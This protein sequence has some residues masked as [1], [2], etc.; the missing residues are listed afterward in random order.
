ME[1]ETK[2]SIDK[3][4]SDITFKVGH[5]VITTLKGVFKNFDASIYTKSK[6]FQ[7][8]EIDFWIEAASVTTG[9]LNRDV[10]LRSVDFFD[11]Q[12][13]MQ[14]K[15]KSTTMGPPDKE[16]NHELWGELIIKGNTKLIKLNVKF[17]G[18][19]NDLNGNENVSC[20]ITGK[21]NRADWGLYGN[22]SFESGGMMVSKEVK[23]LCAL[24]LINLGSEGLHLSLDP[25]GNKSLHSN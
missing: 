2:W 4:N 21:L 22:S 6:D 12:N 14:I 11:V 17:S 7:T 23:I 16:G 15:F 8:A 24:Q 5:L 10:H 18:I 9:D 20:K 19:S 3:I 1:N 25:M 13:Y